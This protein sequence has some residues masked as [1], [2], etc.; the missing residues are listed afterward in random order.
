M[1]V[2]IWS[3]RKVTFDSE[4][5][6]AVADALVRRNDRA[7]CRTAAGRAYYALYWKAHDKAVGGGVDLAALQK[8]L[9]TG[10]HDALSWAYLTKTNRL[11]KPDAAAR[12]IGASLRKLHAHRIA[13]DYKHTPTERIEEQ[14]VVQ[15]LIDDARSAIKDLGSVHW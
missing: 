6:L 3:G 2:K 10:S 5:F 11:K 15:L 4:E 1:F 13:A 8:R 9:G 12:R 7:F 14:A